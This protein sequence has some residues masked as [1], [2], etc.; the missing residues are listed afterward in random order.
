MKCRRNEIYLHNDFYVPEQKFK[1][2]NGVNR[3]TMTDHISFYIVN[4]TIGNKKK[5]TYNVM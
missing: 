3:N 5:N 4:S 2:Y 1:R